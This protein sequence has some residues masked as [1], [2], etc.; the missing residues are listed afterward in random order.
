MSPGLLI[1]FSQSDVGIIHPCHN[2]CSFYLNTPKE[3]KEGSGAQY[4]LYGCPTKRLLE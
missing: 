2:P 3:V 1:R 4:M